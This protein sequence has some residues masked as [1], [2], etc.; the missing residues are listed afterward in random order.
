[1]RWTIMATSLIFTTCLLA[2]DITPLGLAVATDQRTV[3]STPSPLASLHS[4]L[5]QGDKDSLLQAAFSAPAEDLARGYLWVQMVLSWFPLSPGETID[6]IGPSGMTINFDNQDSF[7]EEFSS[8]LATYE[9]SRPLRLPTPLG[10]LRQ[11]IWKTVW[12]P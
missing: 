12:R 5:N 10:L 3:I 9:T 1:M 6:I 2:M 7:R 11:M 8:R 4:K